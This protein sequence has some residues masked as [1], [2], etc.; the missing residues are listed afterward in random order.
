M[1]KIHP[2]CVIIM[3][4]SVVIVDPAFCIEKLVGTGCSIIVIS[5]EY[6]VRGA[7]PYSSMEAIWNAPSVPTEYF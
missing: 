5:S 6:P 2:Y 4:Q 1:A 7:W 3:G